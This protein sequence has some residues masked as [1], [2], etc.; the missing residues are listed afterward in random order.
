M[1]RKYK[2][3]YRVVTDEEIQLFNRAIKENFMKAIKNMRDTEKTNTRR[4]T[5]NY[6]LVQNFRSKNLFRART[7]ILTSQSW[8]NWLKTKERRIK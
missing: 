7:Q 2:E 1:R 4:K 5:F 3:D 8:I 6:D